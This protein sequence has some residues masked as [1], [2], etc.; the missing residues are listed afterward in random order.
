MCFF[1]SSRGDNFLFVM[2]DSSGIDLREFVVFLQILPEAIISL[3]FSVVTC[4]NRSR[5]DLVA[6]LGPAE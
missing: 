5:V 4:L 2:G 6:S 1:F 3:I